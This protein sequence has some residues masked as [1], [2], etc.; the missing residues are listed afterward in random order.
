MVEYSLH[1]WSLVSKYVSACGVVFKL[2]LVA[3]GSIRCSLIQSQSG[4]RPIFVHIL[5]DRVSL[6]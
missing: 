3:F 5:I 1:C 6:G 4:L 2:E